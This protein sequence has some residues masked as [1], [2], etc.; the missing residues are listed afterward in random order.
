MKK[1]LSK[2]RKNYVAIN[3]ILVCAVHIA[4]RLNDR[5]FMSIFYLGDEGVQHRVKRPEFPI[6]AGR[7]LSMGQRLLN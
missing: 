5:F 7:C 1:S 6:A 3:I 4:L 2:S